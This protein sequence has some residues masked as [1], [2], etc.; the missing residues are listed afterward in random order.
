MYQSERDCEEDINRL[1]KIGDAE[2]IKVRVKEL[3]KEKD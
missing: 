1:I 3:Y 2:G